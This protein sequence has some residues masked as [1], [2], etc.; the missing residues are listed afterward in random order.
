M[1]IRTMTR[2]EIDLAVEWAA[3]EGWNPGPSDANA[4]HAEIGRAHV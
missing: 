1:E 4:F 3:R 2:Q